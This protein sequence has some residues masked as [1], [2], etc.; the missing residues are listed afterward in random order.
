MFLLFSHTLTP[1][2]KEDAKKSFG[3]DEFVSLPP[4]LQDLWSNIP[5]EI[6]NLKA[7]L[8]PIERFIK[9]NVKEG[10]VVLVQGD[11]GATCLAVQQVWMQG[12]LPVYATTRRRVV[13]QR[14]G[15]QTHK[16]SLFEHIRFRAY[17]RM[18]G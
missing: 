13:E 10:D 11:F 5:P 1:L 16:V 6:S 2:Q 14:H 17:K 7:Y 15:D 4:D 9:D 3:V 8:K 18:K 12:A